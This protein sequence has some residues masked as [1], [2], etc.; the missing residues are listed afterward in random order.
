MSTSVLEMVGAM[1]FALMYGFNHGIR[2]PFWVLGSFEILH[3]GQKMSF[4][5]YS[6]LGDSKIFKNRRGKEEINE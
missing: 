5:I 2:T 3:P 4:S 6:C 1:E